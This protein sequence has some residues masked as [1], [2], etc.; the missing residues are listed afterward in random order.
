MG[1]HCPNVVGQLQ[2]GPREITKEERMSV[3][4]HVLSLLLLAPRPLHRHSQVC[5]TFRPCPTLVHGANLPSET[6]Q[7][8]GHAHWSAEREPSP[9]RG[10]FAFAGRVDL[11][12]GLSQKNEALIFN[13][14]PQTSSLKETG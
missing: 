3:D 1:T 8:P 11:L 2:P 4:P 5:D 14:Q 7:P 13:F 9:V 12:S 6:R 10:I